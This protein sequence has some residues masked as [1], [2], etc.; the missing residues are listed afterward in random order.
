MTDQPKIRIVVVE[1]HL[2]VRKGICQILEK[3]PDCEIVGEAGDGEQAINLIKN[4]L[5]D[6]LLCDLRLPIIDGVMVVRQV[7]IISPKTNTLIL[8]AYD[9]FEYVFE[10]MKAGAS[11]YLL[12]TIDDKKL[13]EAI[14]IAHSGEFVLPSSL[15]SKFRAYLAGNQANTKE[16]KTLSAREYEILALAADGTKNKIIAE[17]LNLS[18]RTVEKHFEYILDKLSVTSRSEAIHKA[19]DK[20]IIK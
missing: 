18:V 17:K 7:K 14:R 12:K 16:D 4:V 15:A 2:I 3:S 9:D 11:G 10:S 20:H 1:D 5:P 13:L 19:V 6:V 8:S